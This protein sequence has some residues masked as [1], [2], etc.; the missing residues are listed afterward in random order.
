MAHDPSD[1]PIPTAIDVDEARGVTLRK[2]RRPVKPLWL[3]LLEP[4]ASLKLTVVLLAL[5]VVL[6]FIGTLAQWRIETHDATNRYFRVWYARVELGDLMPKNFFP[7]SYR[8]TEA[9]E[10]ADRFNGQG[11][12]T[13]WLSRDI[14]GKPETKKIEE[15]ESPWFPFPGGIPIGILMTLNLLAAH[16][17]KFKVQARGQRVWWGAGTIALGAGMIWWIVDKQQGEITSGISGD[18]QDYLW[19]GIAIALAGLWALAGYGLLTYG[20]EQKQQR[21][22]T[23]LGGLLSLAAFLFV[24]YRVYY[25]SSPL[26]DPNNT[27]IL[28]Q[29]IQAEFAAL[30]LLVGC[31]L[32]FMKRAGVVL[33]HGG[34]LLLMFNELL[35]Y[36]THVEWQMD[37]AEKRSN[38]HAKDVRRLELAIERDLVL[39]PVNAK[40]KV[41]ID[42]KT[43]APVHQRE[44]I[45]I[46]WEQ[47]WNDDAKIST[48]RVSDPLLP[49][50]VEVVQF[51]K[52]TA[53]RDPL[54]GEK[55]L[56][57]RGR[58]TKFTVDEKRPSTSSEGVDESVAW[59]K[60]FPKGSKEP[61]GVYMMHSGYGTNDYSDTITIPAGNDTES[62]QVSLRYKRSYKPYTINLHEVRKDDYLGSDIPR[63]YSSDITLHDAQDNA[64]YDQHIRM[65]EPLRY[66]G[67]TIYQ[68]GFDGTHGPKII[69]DPQTH[70]WRLFDETR[71]FSL[72]N[73]KKTAKVTTLQIVSNKGWMLPYM[74]CM[75]VLTGMA[76]HFMSVATRYFSKYAREGSDL[77]VSLWTSLWRYFLPNSDPAQ[78]AVVS[79]EKRQAKPKKIK[80]RDA[81]QFEVTTSQFD[82]HAP[83]RSPWPLVMTAIFLLAFVGYT[84]YRTLPAKISDDKPDLRGFGELP[85]VFKGRVK[86]LDTLA[87]NSLSLISRQE[88]FIDANGQRQPAIKWLLDLWA[89]FDNFKHH[90]IYFVENPELLNALGL[91]RRPNHLYSFAELSNNRVQEKLESMVRVARTKDPLKLDTLDKKAVELDVRWRV[92]IELLVSFRDPDLNG[93]RLNEMTPADEREK[94]LI[95]AAIAHL[96]ELGRLEA[97]TTKLPL[98]IP[99]PPQYRVSQETKDE[100]LSFY[101]YAERMIKERAPQMA[102]ELPEQELEKIWTHSVQPVAVAKFFD[103]YPTLNHPDLK[104]ARNPYL[105]QFMLLLHAYNQRDFANFNKMLPEYRQSVMAAF[106]AVQDSTD[107]KYKSTRYYAADKVPFESWYNAWNPFAIAMPF[108]MVAFLCAMAGLIVGQR[109]LQPATYWLLWAI[110]IVHTVGLVMRIYLSGHPPVTNLYSSA[111]FIGWGMV[112]LA[113]LL[114]GYA[115]RGFGSVAAG[116]AGF[117]TLLISNGLYADTKN[118]STTGGDTMGVMQAVLDTDFWLATH[119]VTVSLGYATTILASLYGAIYLVSNALSYTSIAVNGKPLDRFNLSAEKELQRA[120]Y[121]TICFAIIFSFVGTVLGGLWADDSWGRFW[122]WDPKENG[123]LIIVLWNALV[124]HARW[125]GMI[126]ER[127]LAVLSLVGGIV[128]G[129]SWFGVNE[130][131][132]GLHSYGFREG[133]MLKLLL[134]AA[135][136]C[137]VMFL[138]LIPRS[139]APIAEV[140]V[141]DAK[142]S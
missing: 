16:G 123:A 83:Y 53:I 79:T 44:V 109:V 63:N 130:L 45:T 128:T 50:D 99:V 111:L 103:E 54:P 41:S 6:V 35:V 89:D 132:V 75:I 36:K 81:T 47:V 138:G 29:L 31:S 133:M 71:D 9:W 95:K 38:W 135:G 34:I 49:F 24:M 46:P 129:W 84:V 43:P 8:V 17:L 131:G 13:N 12:L 21:L 62:F 118:W 100:A 28:W 140:T 86:P 7:D 10:M 110:F 139:A 73:N 105:A 127:G 48:G 88:S 122:G 98:L 114:E 57:T 11:N 94:V 124:L 52:N 93:L 91:P 74:C 90:K 125:G 101:K 106:D 23:A 85:A 92:P 40:T 59:V 142:L 97:I 119:V 33:L 67:Q 3:T 37:V 58:G 134:F 42:P 51:Y 126:K 14:T 66:K 141:D 30:T 32:L 60:I 15:G 121:G 4:L 102:K 80:L 25:L 55:L 137:V 72:E 113:L 136:S 26:L 68:S 65:N 108:Y 20:P 64:D 70:E 107:D 19:S 96:Q 116:A 56:A 27:R 69:E 22:Y 115:R 61:L 112:L 1:L 87:R 78:P 39:E 76:Y 82:V 120:I 5:S 104:H 77:R 2:N 18:V 117:A